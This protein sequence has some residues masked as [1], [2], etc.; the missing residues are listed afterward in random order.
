MGYVNRMMEIQRK[1][2][3]EIPEIKNIVTEMKNDLVD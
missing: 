2:Q 1:Y 3:K